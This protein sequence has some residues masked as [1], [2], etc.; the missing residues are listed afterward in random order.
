MTTQKQ[1]AR[2]RA[3]RRVEDEGDFIQWDNPP[4]QVQGI[5]RSYAKSA[6]FAGMAIELEM[7]DG[8]VRK[9]TAP[10]VLARLIEK[11]GKPIGKHILIEYVK[12]KKTGNGQLKVFELW[13]ADDEDEVPF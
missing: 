11:E 12:D 1:E 8:T 4:M 5:L 9:G 6:S 2:E 3:W 7:E 13:V 10:T